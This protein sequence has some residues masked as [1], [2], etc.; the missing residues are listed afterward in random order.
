L[1]LES[2]CPG[3]R[4]RKQVLISS[5]ISVRTI[6]IML[7]FAQS[8]PARTALLN[9]PDDSRS[10][11]CHQMHGH[12]QL[13]RQLQTRED[14][15][16]NPYRTATFINGASASSIVDRARHDR[17]DIPACTR[18]IERLEH[19]FR[20]EPLSILRLLND[21]GLFGFAQKTVEQAPGPPAEVV[22]DCEKSRH[23]Q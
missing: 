6:R 23:K 1:A 12:L 7:K 14:A 17:R 5:E 19:L 22:H 21:A 9:R 15:F 16:T 18:S 3:A 2:G 13:A 8:E 4:L 20:R 11:L 10:A